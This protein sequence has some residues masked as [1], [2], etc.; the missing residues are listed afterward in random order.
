MKLEYIL[1]I[2]YIQMQLIIQVHKSEYHI[3]GS[4]I[5]KHKLTISP[6]CFILFHLNLYAPSF[7]YT[8]FVV[9]IY[10]I[11]QFHNFTW[12]FFPNPFQF[13]LFRIFQC[14]ILLVHA[15]WHTYF[16]IIALAF[17]INLYPYGS[18]CHNLIFD[19]FILI[20]IIFLFTEK[21]KKNNNDKKNK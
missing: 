11:T 4:S 18:P 2:L 12:V 10:V 15:I 5:N 20:I 13:K 16:H 14:Y 17:M 19:H 1:R 8:Y 21:D 6:I 9:F 7:H 3:H